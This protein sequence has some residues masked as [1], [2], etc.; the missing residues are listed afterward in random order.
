MKTFRKIW[1]EDHQD[2]PDNP[3]QEDCWP[4]PDRE[5]LALDR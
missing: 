5:Y 3:R 1:D 4:T 2:T